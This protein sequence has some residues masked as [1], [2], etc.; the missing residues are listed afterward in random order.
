MPQ[1]YLHYFGNEASSSLLETCG[2]LPKDQQ[3]GQLAEGNNAL[4]LRPKQCPN[5]NEPNRPDGSKFCAKCR[6]VLTY[7]AYSETLAEQESKEKEIAQ[8]RK[9]L[10]DIQ[11]TL[12]KQ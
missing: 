2:I 9:E 4:L 8:L 6:M 5:C 7:D 10:S 3:G 12:P 11:Q 1:C